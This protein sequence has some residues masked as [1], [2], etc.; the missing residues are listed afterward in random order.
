MTLLVFKHLTLQIGAILAAYLCCCTW[1]FEI[2]IFCTSSSTLNYIKIFVKSYKNWLIY[3]TDL[4]KTQWQGLDFRN[5]SSMLSSTVPHSQEG[6]KCLMSTKMNFKKQVF[7]IYLYI[8]YIYT[9]H[10]MH[11]TIY[12]TYIVYVTVYL[13]L[14][15]YIVMYLATW[16]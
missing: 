3:M 14:S 15:I 1:K 11:I 7:S 9:I 6:N 4:K 10:Y 5:L 12:I 2:L 16:K 8:I 13:Y